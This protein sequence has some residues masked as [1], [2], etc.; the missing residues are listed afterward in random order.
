MCITYPLPFY[1]I[2]VTSPVTAGGDA[3]IGRSPQLQMCERYLQLDDP[4]WIKVWYLSLITERKPMVPL[5]QGGSLT[6][7]M[8]YQNSLFA[9][10]LQQ[11]ARARRTRVAAPGSSGSI[12]TVGGDAWQRDRLG[13]IGLHRQPRPFTSEII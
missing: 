5:D 3:P 13:G 1:H 2:V 9:P 8:Y 7:T 12:V 6:H 4:R 11:H 10:A